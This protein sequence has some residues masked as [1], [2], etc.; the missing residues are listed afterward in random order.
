MALQAQR[1]MYMTIFDRCVKLLVKGQGPEEVVAAQ[2]AKEF[3][4]DWG[5]PDVFV[6]AAF[7]SLWGHYAP[8]A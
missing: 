7:K 6:E 1:D 5:N 8:D 3:A 4:G 2:P